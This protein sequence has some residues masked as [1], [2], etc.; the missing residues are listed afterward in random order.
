MQTAKETVQKV[1]AN[2]VANG[3]TAYNIQMQSGEKYGHGFNVPNFKDGDT[4]EFV[5]KQNGKYK[6][7]DPNSVKVVDNTPQTSNGAMP[8]TG[9]VRGGGVSKDEYWANKEK[10][11]V[12]R[13]KEI[14][15]QA[16]RNQAIEVAAIALRADVIK[17]PTKQ[18][19][20]LG[21]L[22]GFIEARTNEFAKQ[23][24]EFVSGNNSEEEVPFDDHEALNDY[25]D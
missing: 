2:T 6:N 7:I 15:Y 5:Y 16:S 18:A 17:L 25:D 1:W 20:R 19:D 13:Q 10:A 22:L 9:N 12:D 24:E 14:R 3:K 21:V 8:N 11:D 23:T 4:I